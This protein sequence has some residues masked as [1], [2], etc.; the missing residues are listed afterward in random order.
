M[1]NQILAEATRKNQLQGTPPICNQF[2]KGLCRRTFCKFRHLTKEQ[3]EAEIVEL[4]QNNTQRKHSNLSRN[5]V[6]ES[7]FVAVASINDVNGKFN[8]LKLKPGHIRTSVT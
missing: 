2:K 3:E 1:S 8:H 4:I 7:P 5:N 6:N